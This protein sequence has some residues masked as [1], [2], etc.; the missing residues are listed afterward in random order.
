[1][2]QLRSTS[3]A[4]QDRRLVQTAVKGPTADSQDA[5]F[6]PLEH[7]AALE[8]RQ[9][10]SGVDFW[11]GTVNGCGRR[12]FTRIGDEK[13]PHFFHQGESEAQC[14][15]AQRNRGWL[16]LEA[17]IV[18]AELRR[19]RQGRDLPEGQ[20]DFF[21]PIDGHDARYMHI[22]GPVGTRDTRIV[23]GDVTTMQVQQD[24]A[25]VQGREWDWFVHERNTQVRAILDSQGIA[26]ARIRFVP[27]AT[28]ATL[29]VFLATPDNVGDWGRISRYV[30]APNRA[31]RP[32]EP[33]GW[34]VTAGS[35]PAP[36]RAPV[37]QRTAASVPARE[38]GNP[39]AQVG[40]ETQL[41]RLRGLDGGPTREPAFAR[42][43]P[44]PRESEPTRRHA[45]AARVP[46]P[47]SEEQIANEF[48]DAIAHLEEAL[49]L[50]TARTRPGAHGA[51]RHCARPT[52]RACPATTT[53]RSR[54]CSGGPVPA[55]RL[56]TTLV[57]GSA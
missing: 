32:P 6:L 27:T 46:A 45:P 34:P 43:V 5:V 47:R 40:P 22:S 26:Y 37:P 39:F 23:L 56:P 50:E 25:S 21:D 4:V 28:S 35:R 3:A 52:A 41:A 18:W 7:D 54:P 49:A 44:R 57:P 17:P 11:C 13:I 2:T 33:A 29:Q 38:Q 9:E 14:R 15:R 16:D 53:E 51:C 10:H 8:F 30:A 24:A 19:W 31:P 12:L 1:M 36:A 20:I 48:K 55:D 42:R